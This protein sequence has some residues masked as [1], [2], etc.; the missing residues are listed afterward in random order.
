MNAFAKV[1]KAT[2]LRFAAEHAEERYEYVRGRI[3]Q[4]LTGGTR[5]HGGVARRITRQLE[6][7][8]DLGRWSVL[9]DRGVETSE[10]IR[11]TDV[12]IEPIDEAGDSLC[13]QRP[14]LIVEVLSRSTAA[15]DL[16]VKPSEYL[17]L[18]SLDAYVIASQ[19]EPALLVYVRGADGRFPA[20]PREIGGHGAILL[21]TTRH[22]SVSLRLADVYKGI[23]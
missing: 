22:F 4:Q 11:Y 18:A 19:T 5:D 7:R 13:T 14:A 6:D 1:D 2:F 9:N 23:A 20:E 21:L 10:T 3:V 17:S 15:T 16:D 8:I 12:V